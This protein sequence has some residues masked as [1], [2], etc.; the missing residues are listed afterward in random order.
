MVD[1]AHIYSVNIQ[2]GNELYKF[3]GNCFFR[4]MNSWFNS[5]VTNLLSINDKLGMRTV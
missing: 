1:I 3:D 4:I 2:S 5:Y